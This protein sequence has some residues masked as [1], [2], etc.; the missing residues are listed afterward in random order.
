MKRF[1]ALLSM[2]IGLLVPLSTIATPAAQ[3]ACAPPDGTQVIYKFRN[4]SFT[5]YPT[6]LKSAWA[7]FPHGGTISYTET[8]TKHVEASV[9]ATVEAEAGIIFAKASASVG[10]TVGGGFSWDRSWSYTTN[11][12]ADSEHKYR[13]HNYHYTVNFGVMKKR[14]LGGAICDYKNA[15]SSWQP[16]RHAPVK[17]ERSVWRVDKRAA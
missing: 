15:W 8:F 16:V 17:A 2:L 4:K 1:V 5:Y 9:T 12:P 3:A 10:V 13:L 7:L 14:W 11:V 6:N